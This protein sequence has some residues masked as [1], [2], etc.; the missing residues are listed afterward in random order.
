MYNFSIVPSTG[1]IFSILAERIHDG[2]RFSHSGE[3]PSPSD[4]QRL[5]NDIEE[6][7]ILSDLNPEFWTEVAPVVGS[8]AYQSLNLKS[9]E[10]I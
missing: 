5:L 8:P 6:C 4:A 9:I 3:F 7:N 1:K 10:G 2:S